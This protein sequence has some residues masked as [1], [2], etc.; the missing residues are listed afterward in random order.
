MRVEY[1]DKDKVVES[2]KECHPEYEGK[3]LT[4]NIYERSYSIKAGKRL[5]LSVQAMGDDVV[6]KEANHIYGYCQICRRGRPIKSQI[7]AVKAEYPSAVIIKETK[8][9]RPEWDKLLRK[10]KPGD[11][12]VFDTI[13]EMSRDADESV[14][15][16]FDLYEKGI[17]L[18]FLRE[19][20]IDTSVY[21]DVGFDDPI[22]RLA[23]K[24]ICI[25]YEQTEKSCDLAH[26]A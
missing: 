21:A 1:I 16:Y 6:Y 10:V 15:I 19:H 3:A 11:T 7:E 12:I 17:R 18:V 5:L 13:F 2:F 9:N 23:K 24:Q 8:A 22:R 14:N 26:G 20:Y 25:A 4:V